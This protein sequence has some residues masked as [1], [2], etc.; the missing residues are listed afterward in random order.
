MYLVVQKR[1][2]HEN[3]SI[4]FY[5]SYCIF[6]SLKPFTTMKKLILSALLGLAYTAQAQTI[7]VNLS[8]VQYGNVN[9]LAPD[10]VTLTLSN[11]WNYDVHVTGVHHYA[12]YNK[13]PF[14]VSDSI[15]TIPANGTKDV[16]VY[17]NIR[18]NIAHNSEI[19][20]LNDGGRGPIIVDVKAQG[21]YSNPYYSSTQNLSEENLKQALRTRISAGYNNLGYSGARDKMF[22]EI[23]N[24]KLNGQNAPINTLE[25]VYTGLLATGYATRTDAQNMGFNTEHTFPQAFFNQNEPMRAD[26]YHLYPTDDAANNFRG[27]SPFGMVTNPTWSQG[28]SKGIS[29]LFEPRDVHKGETA[30]AMFYFVVRYQDY[31]CFEQGQETILKQ[32]H[33]DFPTTTIETMRNQ[34]IS[35]VQANRNPF[36][37]YPQFAERMQS[38]GC[39]TSV[40]NTYYS[41]DIPEE[42]IYFYD[43]TVGNTAYY[44]AVL[45]NNGTEPITFTG[46]QLDDTALSFVNGTGADQ[47]IASGDAAILHIQYAPTSAGAATAY[48]GVSTNMSSQPSV[49]IPIHLNAVTA[50]DTEAE[51]WKIYPNPAQNILHISHPVVNGNWA[52]YQA[53]G[54]KVAN[55]KLSGEN[56]EILTANLS[57]GLYYWRSET[58]TGSQVLKVQILK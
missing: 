51:K 25:C 36:I 49:T 38:I 58:A 50:L 4:F 16:K 14:T 40:A 23:D 26:L 57:D 2:F 48:M 11:P 52:L 53:N 43:V 27:N 54:Q 3:K 5:Q 18:H 34:A 44:Q 45:V 55:G 46:F 15:F 39:N 8:N 22:M 32:W 29:S 35:S 41:L 13:F 28:G 24:K 21:E 1:F 9:E 6:V 56:T 31:S 47:T 17:A 30:R 20:F 42:E 10:S 12:L 33:K 7:S 37:D 19:V